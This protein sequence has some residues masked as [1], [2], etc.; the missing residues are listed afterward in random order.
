L[1]QRWSNKLSMQKLRMYLSEQNLFT[2]TDYSG[3]N[4]EVNRR[5]MNALT[6]GED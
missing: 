4:P 1:P 2:R 5:P 6:S 3:Y